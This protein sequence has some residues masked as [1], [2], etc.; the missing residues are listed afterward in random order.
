MDDPNCPI[1]KIDVSVDDDGIVCE[2]CKVWSHRTCLFMTEEE[3]QVLDESDDAWFCA[4][5]SSIM[6][7]KINLGKLN[8]ESTII[9]LLFIVK[10]SWQTVHKFKKKILIFTFKTKRT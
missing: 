8:N 9:Y 4:T 5:C 10:N 3:Y 7:K 2:M 6:A 1:C